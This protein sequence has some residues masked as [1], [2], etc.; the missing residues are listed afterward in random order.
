MPPLPKTISSAA[1]YMTPCL[2]SAAHWYMPASAS[3]SVDTD[4]T[5]SSTWIL[6]CEEK[7]GKVA[8]YCSKREGSFPR[9]AQLLYLVVKRCCADYCAM[10]EQKIGP[11][12]Q[13]MPVFFFFLWGETFFLKAACTLELIRMSAATT[14]ILT[15][16]GQNLK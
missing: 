2:F 9:D 12:Y 15:L 1:K 13:N 3:V 11:C 16:L 4:S 7:G 5:P 6:S 8:D 14:T 10:S